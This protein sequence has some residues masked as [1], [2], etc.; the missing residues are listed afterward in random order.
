M[1]RFFPLL[2]ALL[3]VP[4]L[5]SAREMVRLTR[6][7]GQRIAGVSASHMFEVVLVK[8]DA[9]KAVVEI[10]GELESYL[11][12][13]CKED[14]VVR[15]GLNL[16][17][18]VQRRIERNNGW[19]NRTLKLTLYLPD[20]H[21]I[22]LSDM[23]RLTS[24]SPFTAE[25]A[26]IKVEDMAKITNL[27]LDAEIV[28]VKAEDMAGVNL[29]L[30]ADKA[31]LKADD[32][33]K[34]NASGECR[35]AYAESNDMARINANGLKAERATLKAADMAK[36]SMYVSRWLY[37]RSSDMASIDYTGDPAEID[38]KTPRRTV[39]RVNP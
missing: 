20:F 30:W 8:S 18:D 11:R 21:T 16:P 38:L 35:E 26:R 15:V 19:R 32:M 37:A 33:A 4:A 12:F 1:K 39:Y 28:T 27:N 24:S 2:F 3:S 17:R 34:I 25:Q 7:D 31:T 23:A 29:T 14:G 9:T 6:Y 10:D 5:L 36:T 22:E 13:E